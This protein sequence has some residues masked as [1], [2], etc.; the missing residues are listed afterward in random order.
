MLFSPSPHEAVKTKVVWRKTDEVWWPR[1]PADPNACLL[2]VE[3]VTAELWDG[4]ASAAIAA[5]EFA[6][7]RLTGEQPKPDENCKVTLTM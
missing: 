7:A 1:G 3:P 6:N 5:I 2:F 4:P